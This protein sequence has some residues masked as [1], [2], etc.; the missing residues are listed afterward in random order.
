MVLHWTLCDIDTH[1][2]ILTLFTKEID[3]C[4]FYYTGFYRM[5]SVEMHGSIFAQKYV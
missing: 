3:W 2:N 1:E 4:Y 5:F